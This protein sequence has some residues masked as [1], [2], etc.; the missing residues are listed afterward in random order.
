MS[1]MCVF[2]WHRDTGFF[3]V[4][5]GKGGTPTSSPRASA[6]SRRWVGV[7]EG[8]EANA[9]SC[10]TTAFDLLVIESP[11]TSSPWNVR[12]FGC[13]CGT[14]TSMP[15]GAARNMLAFRL[16]SSVNRMSSTNS[17]G[18]RTAPER[19]G[20]LQPLPHHR[21]RAG[22]L[23]AMAQASPPALTKRLARQSSY[24]LPHEPRIPAI[25]T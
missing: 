2:L 4:C 5:A 25:R 14:P 3:F 21:P 18:H 17:D 15:S 13:H 16:S 20:D 23:S 12:N 11:T 6:R 19:R 7:N 22:N 8:A 24:Q 9:L 10:D 1:N